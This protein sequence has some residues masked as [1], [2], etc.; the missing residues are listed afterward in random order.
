MFINPSVHPSGNS[1]LCLLS[2]DTFTN[3]CTVAA[4][5]SE[6]MDCASGRAGQSPL[7]LWP[8]YLLVALLHCQNV[9]LQ[10]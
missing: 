6:M 8:F 4:V 2:C 5:K 1:L 9:L 3:I 10:G 7:T